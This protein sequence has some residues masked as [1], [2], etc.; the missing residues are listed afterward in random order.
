M[1][2]ILT[3]IILYISSVSIT[4]FYLEKKQKILSIGNVQI[5]YTPKK[6]LFRGIL[7]GIII[8]IAVLLSNIGSIISGI[9][10]VF[11]AILTSTML[12]SIREHGPDFAA[13]MAKSMLLGLSSVVT[14]AT[15]IHFLYPLIGI[16][17]GS[18][19]AYFFSFIV[20]LSLFMIRRKIK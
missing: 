1:N 3:S 12:I 15:L 7:A 20:T 5:H 13:G 17:I 4:F 8:A 16:I 2:Q 9:F 11:P 19:V 10:S 18:I 6:I 14:Y